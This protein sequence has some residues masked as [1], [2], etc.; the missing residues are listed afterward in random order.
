META[1]LLTAPED[2][3]RLIIPN[4]LR[5]GIASLSRILRA[6]RPSHEEWHWAQQ[7]VLA[8]APDQW[9]ELRMGGQVTGYVKVRNSYGRYS[10]TRP[11]GVPDNQIRP[12]EATLPPPTTLRNFLSLLG[13]K[14]AVEE[15]IE[16]AYVLARAQALRED[17]NA[18]AYAESRILIDALAASFATQLTEAAVMVEYE[19]SLHKR[20][21]SFDVRGDLVGF[22]YVLTRTARAAHPQRAISRALRESEPTNIHT[23]NEF[24]DSLLS[25]VTRF[26]GGT[27]W[28]ECAAGELAGETE[29]TL[30]RAS[31]AKSVG[32]FY[33]AIF[34]AVPLAYGSKRAYTFLANA[35]SADQSAEYQRLANVSDERFATLVS[36]LE[37]DFANAMDWRYVLSHR[38]EIERERHRKGDW[39]AERLTDEYIDVGMVYPKLFRPFLLGQTETLTL[40]AVEAPHTN[41]LS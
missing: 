8:V 21:L 24:L 17:E 3:S 28:I 7:T 38:R 13:E 9:F 34:E 14:L 36:A 15:P 37:I 6:T 39:A 16:A 22:M 23:I 18:T 19:K 33:G 41:K 10:H 2:L 30:D 29:A 32:E 4:D 12:L 1:N 25:A 31:E 5:Y 35:T 40:S 27:G 20:Y 26:D 11:E